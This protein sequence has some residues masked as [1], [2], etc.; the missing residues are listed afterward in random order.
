[1]KFLLITLI[2]TLT[3][4]NGQL[5]TLDASA[6]TPKEAPGMAVFY[7]NEK[8]SPTACTEQELLYL[9]SKMMPDI[10]MTLLEN[11]YAI[12][13]WQTTGAATRRQL[14]D[15]DGTDGVLV[16]GKIDS[17]SAATASTTTSSSNCDFCRRYYP[18][19]YCNGM[20]NCGFRRQLRDGQADERKLNDL[21]A[22][23]LAECQQSIVSLSYN[24]FLSRSCKAALQASVCHVELV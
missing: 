18:R 1:M 15:T 2:F 11:N 4:V 23:L 24:R 21:A 6:F 19:S 3:A 20:F 13:Q 17:F 5:M 9:D 10:D 14:I 7:V 22:D 12:P 16:S 8:A